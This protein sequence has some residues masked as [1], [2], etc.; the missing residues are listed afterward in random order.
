MYVQRPLLIICF[1]TLPVDPE[2]A[3]YIALKR[4]L[5][6]AHGPSHHFGYEVRLF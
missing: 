4:Y 1:L 2:S 5:I 6:L 3:E